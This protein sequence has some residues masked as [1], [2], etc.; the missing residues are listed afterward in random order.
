[1]LTQSATIRLDL[2]LAPMARVVAEIL[3]ALRRV[4]EGSR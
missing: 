4:E 3:A 2:P 1:M